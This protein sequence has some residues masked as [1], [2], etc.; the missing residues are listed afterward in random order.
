VLSSSRAAEL[1][2]CSVV[3][4]MP[5]DPPPGALAAPADLDGACSQPTKLHLLTG[6][7]LEEVLAALDAVGESLTAEDRVPPD[8]AELA[9]LEL[10]R[11]VVFSPSALGG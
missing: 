10:G 9:A 8:A 5:V 11:V 4:P 6:L 3:A 7:S 1:C 2:H